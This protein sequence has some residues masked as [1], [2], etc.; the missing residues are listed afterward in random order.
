MTSDPARLWAKPWLNY[1]SCWMTF[2]LPLVPHF[3][4]PQQE[5]GAKN[6]RMFQTKKDNPF[7]KNQLPSPDILVPWTPTVFFK[8]ITNVPSSKS[9]AHAFAFHDNFCKEISMAAFSLVIRYSFLIHPWYSFIFKLISIQ[10]IDNKNNICSLSVCWCFHYLNKPV[11]FNCV[12]RN[13]GG[14][15]DDMTSLGNFEIRLQWKR[16]ALGDAWE[17]KDS[18]IIHSQRVQ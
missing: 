11:Y 16:T 3:H 18:V 15:A 6:R 13:E 5:T 2:L 10:A 17:G 14:S 1:T 7:V 12:L 4:P 9:K 8:R